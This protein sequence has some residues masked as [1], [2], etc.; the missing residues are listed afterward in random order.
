MQALAER[1]AGH[2][3]AVQMQQVFDLAQNGRHAAGRVQVFHVVLAGRLQVHQHGRGVAQ[4]VEPLQIDF[5]T[6]A[7][8]NRGKV[9]HRIGRPADRQQHAQRIFNGVLP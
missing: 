9:D 4:F 3:S 6:E 8:G 7:P 2:H 1:L 5:Q